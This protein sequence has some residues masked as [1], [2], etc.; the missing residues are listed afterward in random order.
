V[1]DVRGFKSNAIVVGEVTDQINKESS[2]S[3]A[4]IS[5]PVQQR[6]KLKTVDIS[7]RV[8]FQ[9]EFGK[10]QTLTRPPLPIW[11]YFLFRDVWSETHHCATVAQDDLAEYQSRKCLN[12]QDRLFQGKGETASGVHHP[13]AEPKNLL[14]LPCTDSVS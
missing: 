10:D 9:T 13:S 3:P 12:C 14:K 5:V 1:F 2:G 4:F 11:R 8:A 7:R 6:Q